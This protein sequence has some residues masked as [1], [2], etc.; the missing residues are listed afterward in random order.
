MTVWIRAIRSGAINTLRRVV[1]EP[2]LYCPLTLVRTRYSSKLEF[3][4][5]A[6]LLGA[7]MKHTHSIIDKWPYKLKLRPGKSGA[8]EEFDRALG[9]GLSSKERYVEWRL[10]T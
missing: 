6:A 10:T 7:A 9:G 2:C 8:Q 4:K 5:A 1:S 3:Q